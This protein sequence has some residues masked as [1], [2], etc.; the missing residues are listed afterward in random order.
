VSL[1]GDREFSVTLSDESFNVGDGGSLDP[2]ADEGAWVKATV[3]QISSVATGG[4]DPTVPDAGSTLVL[5]GGAL[6]GAASWRR[7]R[8]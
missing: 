8:K 2:G 1:P 5:L 4:G 7:F 3:K 6:I